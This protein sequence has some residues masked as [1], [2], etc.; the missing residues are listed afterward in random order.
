MRILNLPSAF[1]NILSHAQRVL[2]AERSDHSTRI[3]RRAALPYLL[4][5][6]PSLTRDGRMHYGRRRISSMGPKNNRRALCA[7]KIGRLIRAGETDEPEALPIAQAPV[8]SGSAIAGW[9][10]GI[11]N[12]I[13]LGN[14]S[15]LLRYL[16]Q[17]AIREQFEAVSQTAQRS[18]TK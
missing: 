11:R 8:R 7:Q 15:I 17:E 14:G 12:Q 13:R 16:F 1:R 4:R 2:S 6:S 5:R 9:N 10:Q 18:W 3:G